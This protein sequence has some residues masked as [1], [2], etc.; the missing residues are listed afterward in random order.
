VVRYILMLG[1]PTLWFAF[2]P[3]VLW[4][5]WRAVA[6]RDPSAL[7]VLVAVVAGWLT[8]FVNL[9]RT[10]FLFYMAPAAPFFVLAV[11][12]ALQD[13]LG[14][15]GAEPVRR[16]IGLAVVCGYLALVAATFV[17]FYPVLTGQPLSHAEWLQRM[18]FPSWF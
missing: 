8:W 11:T 13:V 2:V 15:R 17:F 12:L 5:V 9:E 3:A 16:Q 14:R 6:R 1:T 10:M 18:W 7:P 4:L